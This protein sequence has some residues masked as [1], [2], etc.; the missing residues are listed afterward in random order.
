MSTLIATATAGGSVHLWSSNRLQP[1]TGDQPLEEA[2]DFTVHQQQSVWNEVWKVTSQEA[3]AKAAAVAVSPDGSMVRK[4]WGVWRECKNDIMFGIS[5]GDLFMFNLISF[6][7]LFT[8]F[9]PFTPFM[10]YS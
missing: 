5:L 10:Y 2:S 4:W 6:R 7:E 1:T 8:P 9:T 3:G